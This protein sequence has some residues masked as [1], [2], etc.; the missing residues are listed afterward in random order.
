[1][2]N[3]ECLEKHR[4]NRKNVGNEDTLLELKDGKK[5][6]DD[7]KIYIRKNKIGPH[8]SQQNIY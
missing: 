3:H 1:M 6:C 7:F 2:F 5:Y 4:D 8:R